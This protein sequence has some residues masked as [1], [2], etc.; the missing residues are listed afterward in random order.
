MAGGN[1]GDAAA[2]WAE[3]AASTVHSERPGDDGLC[4]DCAWQIG[5]TGL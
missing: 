2:G 3:P 1:A 5:K 4:T